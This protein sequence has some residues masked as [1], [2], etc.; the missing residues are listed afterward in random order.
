MPDIVNA[1]LV[2]PKGILLG[3]AAQIVVPIQIGGVYRAV[4]LKRARA[5]KAR[6]NGKSTRNSD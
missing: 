1:V 6:S 3:A 2:G 5:L 4:M